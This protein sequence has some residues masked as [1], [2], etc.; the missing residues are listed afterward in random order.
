MCGHLNFS[1]L[2]RIF[3]PGANFMILKIIS[4]QKL[5]FLLKIQLVYAKNDLNIGFQE[6][7]RFFAE[8]R[9]QL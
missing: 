1:A 6:K 4:P 9:R 8:N 5:A 7:C 2:Q 3:K